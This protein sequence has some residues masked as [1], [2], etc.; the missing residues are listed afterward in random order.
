MNHSYC[1]CTPCNVSPMYHQYMV[2]KCTDHEQKHSSGGFRWTR[3]LRCC[4]SAHDLRTSTLAHSNLHA[5]RHCWCMCG[6]F[7]CSSCT[8]RFNCNWCPVEFQCRTSGADCSQSPVVSAHAA[9]I[10]CLILCTGA[11]ARPPL[12]YLPLHLLSPPLHPVPVSCLP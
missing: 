12:D 7:S 10:Q 5:F 11:S 2:F 3:L 8:S 1:M 4:D 9:L 6:S